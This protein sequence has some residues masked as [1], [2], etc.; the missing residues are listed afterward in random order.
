MRAPMGDDAHTLRRFINNTAQNR[1][2]AHLA[3]AHCSWACTSCSAQLHA[4]AAHYAAARC[5]ALQHVAL[6]CSTSHCVAPGT[7]C[8]ARLHTLGLAMQAMQASHAMLC[9]AGPARPGQRYRVPHPPSY[10]P[11][12]A[13]SVKKT[14]GTS[15]SGELSQQARGAGGGR[16][17]G[18]LQCRRASR[19]STPYHA[20]AHTRR[21]QVWV[22]SEQPSSTRH[23]QLTSSSLAGAAWPTRAVCAVGVGRLLRCLTVV[24]LRKSHAKCTLDEKCNW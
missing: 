8:S 20:H 22:W 21:L 11:G 23:R 12:A 24:I 2:M 18:G 5:T 17:D 4:H 10:K 19:P 14:T 15:G 13:C 3:K 6:R 9:P 16:A 7:S 1:R